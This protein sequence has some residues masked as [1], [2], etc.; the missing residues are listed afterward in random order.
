MGSAIT[1]K[2]TLEKTFLR[3]SENDIAAR[4]SCNLICAFNLTK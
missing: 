3:H 1:E 4:P 2:T